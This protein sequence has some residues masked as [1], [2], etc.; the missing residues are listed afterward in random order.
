[1]GI[2]NAKEAVPALR[3]LQLLGYLCE[4]LYKFSI[5]PFADSHLA[6]LQK[7]DDRRVEQSREA[8][9]FSN[10]DAVEHRTN[11]QNVV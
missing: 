4:A 2:R 11:K 1:L 5:R 8:S 6:R 3:N 7:S 9:L 10:V